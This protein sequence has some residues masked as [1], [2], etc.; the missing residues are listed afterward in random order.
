MLSTKFTQWLFPREGG[1]GR[2]AGE[3][4]VRRCVSGHVLV[5]GLGGVFACVYY[6]IK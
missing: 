3:A 1:E 6:I 4:H 5:L 2:C